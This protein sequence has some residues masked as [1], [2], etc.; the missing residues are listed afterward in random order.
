MAKTPYLRNNDEEIVNALLHAVGLGLALAGTASLVTSCMGKSIEHWVGALCFS[1]T[2]VFTYC[3]STLYHGTMD[4]GKKRQWR[5]WDHISIYAAIAGGWS[6]MFLLW[7]GAPYN[8][9]L[10]SAV[11]VLAMGGSLYK[12]RCLGKNEMFSLISYILMGWCGFAPIL[13]GI[14]EVPIGSG[15]WLLVGGLFYTGGSYF[16]YTDFK[17]YFHSLWHIAVILGSL[18]HYIAVYMFILSQG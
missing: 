18:C 17:P 8:W 6:P 13:Y 15:A 9:I 2:L 5:L 16:Y 4:P 1:L 7:T 11:W 3:M 12:F 10:F 14:T